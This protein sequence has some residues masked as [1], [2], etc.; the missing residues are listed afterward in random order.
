MEP[1]WYCT[2]GCRPF[3]GLEDHGY[4]EK[5]VVFPALARND[6]CLTVLP[7]WTFW[8]YYTLTCEHSKSQKP[9]KRNRMIQRQNNATNNDNSTQSPTSTTPAMLTIPI[10]DTA[11]PLSIPLQGPTMKLLDPDFNLKG[12]QHQEQLV[13][14]TND[15]VKK[16]LTLLYSSSTCQ[17]YYWPGASGM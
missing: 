6:T 13:N 3:P 16:Q 10:P 17:D 9:R 5:E 4:W 12:N 14:I 15:C 7:K 1:G 2:W 8:G 11:Q